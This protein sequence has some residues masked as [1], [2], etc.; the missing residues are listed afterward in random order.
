MHILAV[1]GLL[2]AAMGGCQSAKIGQPLTATLA[3]ADEATQMEFWHALSERRITSNDEAFHALL[4]YFAQKDEAADYAGR[5]A[6]LQ[7]RGMLRKG[8][9]E[10]PDVA[11]RRGTLAL[12]MLKGMQIKGGLILQSLGLLDVAPERYAHRELQYR[13]ILPPGSE[14]QTFSG[15]EFIGL[16]AKVED[17]QREQESRKTA[18]K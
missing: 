3:G 8:F 13:N 12:A 14:H 16:I 15:A 9:N 5:I 11:V 6:A 7:E 10:P 1:L 4:L 2:A 17:F 18:L